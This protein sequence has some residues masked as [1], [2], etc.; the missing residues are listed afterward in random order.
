MKRQAARWLFLVPVLLCGALACHGEP[1]AKPSPTATPEPASATTS[2]APRETATPTATPSPLASPTPRLTATPNPVARPSETPAVTATPTR[3]YPVIRLREVASEALFDVH[4]D[5]GE[6]VTEPGTYVLDVQSGSVRG[7]LDEEPGVLSAPNE[8]HLLLERFLPEDGAWVPVLYD[9][10][11]GRAFTWN[12]RSLHLVAGP[13][14]NSGPR[15]VFRLGSHG[16]FVALDGDLEVTRWFEIPA[17]SASEARASGPPQA[18]AHPTE[19]RLLLYSEGAFHVVGL[20][21]GIPVS[22]RA[23]GPLRGSYARNWSLEFGVTIFSSGDGFG[24]IGRGRDETCRVVRYDWTGRVLSDVTVPCAFDAETEAPWEGPH[25]SPDGKLVAA[26]TLADEFCVCPGLFRRLTATSVFSATTGEELFRVRGATWDILVLG[27]SVYVGASTFWL[28]DSSGLVIDTIHGRRIVSASGEWLGLP[29]PS[30]LQGALVPSPEEP[31]LFLLDP[32]TVVDENGTVL[33]TVSVEIDS[34]APE[35]P[36]NVFIDVVGRWGTT[37]R[38]VLFSA[39]LSGPTSFAVLRPILPPVIERAPIEERLLVR[40]A[41]NGA[42]LDVQEEPGRGAGTVTC[43]EDGSTVEV[44]EFGRSVYYNEAYWTD[45][46]YTATSDSV[47]QSSW[48]TWI[49]I[50]TDDGT[51]GWALSDH[52]RWATGEPPPDSDG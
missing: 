23:P 43:L 15:V 50:R 45:G 26:N 37:N 27:A 44:V 3:T 21:D 46:G 40:V 32:T 2:P 24:L 41:R 13:G 11:S 4:L 52:L 39:H 17:R 42:C 14:T 31:P 36:P 34:P 18:W 8:R 29:V 16:P 25:L 33:A 51:Q 28:P 38:D 9:P 22:I 7:I 6:P 47:C 20:S 1:A 49:Y 19:E 5:A 35:A 12:D 30:P 48:C 10:I